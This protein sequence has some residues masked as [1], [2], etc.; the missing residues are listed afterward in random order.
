MLV[1]P[2]AIAD[3]IQ[4]EGE[5]QAM[6]LSGNQGVALRIQLDARALDAMCP[7]CGQRSARVHSRYVRTL[8]DLALQGTPVRLAVRVRRF[9]CNAPGCPRSTFVE[10]LSV[11]T[12]PRARRTHRL[13]AM[14]TAVV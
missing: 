12:A 5:M 10:P 13:A 3:V 8:A 4:V 9:R 11:L 6:D 14:Q 1:V 7:H 2:Q